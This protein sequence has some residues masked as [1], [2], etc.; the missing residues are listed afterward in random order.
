LRP[1]SRR[2][3]FGGESGQLQLPPLRHRFQRFCARTRRQAVSH[4]R[5]PRLGEH[6]AEPNDLSFVSGNPGSPERLRTMR[7]LEYLRDHEL[8]E[9]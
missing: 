1:R 4:P 9:S 8:V 6:A 2:W 5:S 3:S 7:E